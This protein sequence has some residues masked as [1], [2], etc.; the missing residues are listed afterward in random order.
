MKVGKFLLGV[1]AVGA[2]VGGTYLYLEKNGYIKCNTSEE[3]MDEYSYNYDENGNLVAS[4]Q[5]RKYV[6][7]DSEALKK[8]ASALASNLKS[9]ATNLF[10]NAKQL[11]STASENLG[12][13]VEKTWYE[14]PD[15]VDDLKDK[16]E[17]TEDPKE[18]VD[19]VVEEV[20]EE[21]VEE[22]FNDEK[23]Y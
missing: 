10:E 17:I 20:S 12:D 11:A 18:V 13:A 23:S 22:F 1:A 15:I 6:S 8:D 19:E 5:P 2:A 3:D 14:T 4:S 16:V 21:V 9:K 7:I